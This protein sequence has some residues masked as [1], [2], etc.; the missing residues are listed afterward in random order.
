VRDHGDYTRVQIAEDAGYLDEPQAQALGEQLLD[1]V[2]EFGAGKFVLDLANVHY[3]TSTT[4]DNLVLLNGRLNA[5]GGRLTL[6]NLKP[7][8]HELFEITRLNE[9]L[10][11][12]PAGEAAG[13]G[14]R[15]DSCWQTDSVSV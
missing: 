2:D 12:H 10:Q 7:H 8:I 5:T 4:L 11:I 13:P 9:L 6:C 3:L 1:L 15:Q 14:G